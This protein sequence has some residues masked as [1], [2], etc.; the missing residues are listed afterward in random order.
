M[1]LLAI[2]TSTEIASLALFEN[3]NLLAEYCWQVG[4]N[5]TVQLMPCLNALLEQ[6]GIDIHSVRG[7]GIAVGP[8]SFNGLRVGIASAKGLALSLNVPIFGI[9]T[10]EI[11][12]YQ[13]AFCGPPV[14]SMI[15]A[16]R[17]EIA[18][19]L[20]QKKDN[21]WQCLH[22]EYLTTLDLLSQTIT[23]PTIF[24]GECVAEFGSELIARLGDRAIIPPQSTLFRRAGFLAELA[25]H[26]LEHGDEDNLTALQ[27]IYLRRPHITQPK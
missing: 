17:G 5:H 9:S 20:Y 13:V 24:T 6:T 22:K 21:C 1:I 27:P 3:N 10:L 2:D 12:A 23:E 25:L 4:Q 19:A 11:A 7:I 8:G 26:R 15:K 18:V 14:C 16:G